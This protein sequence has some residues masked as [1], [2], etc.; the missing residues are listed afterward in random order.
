M[1]TSSEKLGTYAITENLIE[2]A[3]DMGLTVTLYFDKY[4]HQTIGKVLI[5]ETQFIRLFDASEEVGGFICKFNPKA[6][7]PISEGDKHTYQDKDGHVR[8]RRLESNDRQGQAEQ[9]AEFVKFAKKGKVVCISDL[10]IN[11]GM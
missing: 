6:S 8:F 11:H 4:E 3:R 2:T 9:R 7:E 10:M 5:N 1:E